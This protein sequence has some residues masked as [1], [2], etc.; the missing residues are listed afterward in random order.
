MVE[1]INTKDVQH[2]LHPIEEEEQK[3]VQEKCATCD[4]SPSKL[5]QCSQCHKV[6]Y[7][8]AECQ[9][10]DWPE[11]KQVCKKRLSSLAELDKDSLK[12]DDFET[13]KKLGDGN[14]TEVF[15]V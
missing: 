7:C 6:A 5:K 12:I 14:F 11:H 10:K 3:A 15:K 13:I 4:E 9:K 1:Q 2:D 8:T